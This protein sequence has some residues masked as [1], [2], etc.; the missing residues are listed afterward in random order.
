MLLWSC[1]KTS[2]RNDCKANPDLILVATW[3]SQLLS[4]EVLDAHRL[5]KSQTFF[6]F[7]TKCIHWIRYSHKS[8][9]K[10]VHCW[11]AGNKC[12]CPGFAQCSVAEM[13]SKPQPAELINIFPYACI[14]ISSVSKIHCYLIIKSFACC[15]K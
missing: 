8:A 15:R 7:L 1:G 9:W 10:I 12:N 5:K 3:C 2:W 6:F 11:L 4:S 13:F 14:S